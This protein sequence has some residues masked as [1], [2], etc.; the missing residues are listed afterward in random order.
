M[1][2]GP[3]LYTLGHGDRQLAEFLA[4]LDDY[5]VRA[6]ADVRSF[7]ASRRQ[8][9]FTREALEAAVAESGRLYRWFGRE[10]GG[11]RAVPYE[12]HMETALFRQG[13]DRLVA[14]ARAEVTAVVCAERDPAACHRRHLARLLRAEGFEIRH[15]LEPGRLLPPGED[16]GTLFPF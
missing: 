14:L 12:E 5:E 4:C 7:P 9:W 1:N 16:Q 2:A 8:P 10:L 15:I 6:V 13:M 3:L 11:M